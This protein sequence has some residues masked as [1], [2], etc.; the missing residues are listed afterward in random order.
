[1]LVSDSVLLNSTAQ[2]KGGT[3]FL[4][5]S[6]LYNGNIPMP[7]RMVLGDGLLVSDGSLVSDGLL[8]SDST[9]SQ[10]GGIMVHGDNTIGMPE[11]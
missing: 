1:L 4:A 2:I 7:D 3:P 9:M 11:Q 10:T 8:V 6:N 5:S